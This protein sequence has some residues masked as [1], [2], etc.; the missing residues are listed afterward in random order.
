[1][2]SLTLPDQECSLPNGRQ[3]GWRVWRKKVPAGAS[4]FDRKLARVIKLADGRAVEDA[5]RLSHAAACRLWL[6]Q[7]PVGRARSLHPAVFRGGRARRR[8]WIA[9]ATDQIEL[10]LRARRLQYALTS[11][12]RLLYALT[13]K[14]APGFSGFS[15]MCYAMP[16]LIG[17]QVLECEVALCR[18]CRVGSLCG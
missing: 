9:A 3:V 10:V 16:L 5:G 8:E 1:M 14:G 18:P 12:R 2:P 6:G 4:I 13:A 7:R 17:F 15:L 11:T